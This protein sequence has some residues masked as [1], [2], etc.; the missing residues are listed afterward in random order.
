MIDPTI[1]T[2]VR[3]HTLK[4]TS[5]SVHQSVYLALP[6]QKIRNAMMVKKQFVKSATGSSLA[7]G[8]LRITLKIDPMLR[9]KQISF[10]IL[11][12]SA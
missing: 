8:A 7:R 10:A 4:E 2:S 11:S 1:A 6:T 3:R 12:R 9:V 5:T